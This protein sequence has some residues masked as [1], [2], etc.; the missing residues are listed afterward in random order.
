MNININPDSLKKQASNMDKYIADFQIGI[1]SI[2]KTIDDI[3]DIWRD[4]AHL[5]FNNQ[6][7]KFIINLR[8][9]QKSLESYN[10][11]I[12]G[13]ANTQEKLDSYYGTKKINLN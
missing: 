5:N 12:K 1:D 9:F 13:Y 6:M 11:F 8:T 3:N 4:N 2:E 10:E 7:N